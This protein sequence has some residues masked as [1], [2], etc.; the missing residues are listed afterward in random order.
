METSGILPRQVLI[1]F[2]QEL[3]QVITL[4]LLTYSIE[5]LNQILKLGSDERELPNSMLDIGCGPGDIYML[6]NRKDCLNAR[7]L[8]VK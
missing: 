5:R 4:R 8:D 2:G 3:P 7:L 6:Q 1:T